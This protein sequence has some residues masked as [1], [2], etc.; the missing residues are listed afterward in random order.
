MVVQAES[1]T[2]AYPIQGGEPFVLTDT[3]GQMEIVVF[4]DPESESA[5]AYEIN[6]E[7]NVINFIVEDSQFMDTETNSVW[8]LGGR[9]V[10]GP[11][12]GERLRAIFLLILSSWEHG[13]SLQ[14][15]R[16]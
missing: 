3:M 1:E 2:R 7:Q 5:A 14:T 6:P 12:S 13:T 11:L 15:L 4:V 10:D 8:N 9:A 16:G